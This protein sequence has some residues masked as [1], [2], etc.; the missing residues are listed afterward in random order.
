[1]KVNDR[2]APLH[3]QPNLSLRGRANVQGQLHKHRT[4]ERIKEK[5]IWKRS[6]Q[7]VGLLLHWRI[8]KVIHCC[9]TFENLV[10]VAT[11][12]GKLQHLEYYNTLNI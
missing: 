2:V 12:I 10:R 7:S 5:P 8:W 9:K 3:E 1:M 11:T 6:Q 4:A